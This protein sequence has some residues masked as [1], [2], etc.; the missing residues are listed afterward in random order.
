MSHSDRVDWRKFFADSLVGDSFI[1]DKPARASAASSA[2]RHG[3]KLKCRKL[4]DGRYLCKI[5]E[6]IDERQR[7][8]AELALLPVDKLRAI[9]KAA[10]QAKIIK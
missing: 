6:A 2:K 7:I 8:L 1:A 5:V 9:Y 4:H 3:V 10:N